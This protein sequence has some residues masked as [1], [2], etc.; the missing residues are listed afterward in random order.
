[1][2][3]NKTIFFF[4]RTYTTEEYEQYINAPNLQIRNNF[5][6]MFIG[7]DKTM[8]VK[9]LYQEVFNKVKAS[10]GNLELK[11]IL[12]LDNESLLSNIFIIC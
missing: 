9:E 1:M 2:F 12:I 3:S 5:H 11:N 6:L 8:T 7:L 10:V 4:F